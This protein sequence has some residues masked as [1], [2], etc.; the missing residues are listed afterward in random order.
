[1]VDVHDKQSRHKNMAAIRNK[2]TKPERDESGY[3]V[4]LATLKSLTAVYQ[5]VNSTRLI[6]LHAHVSYQYLR[7]QALMG[8]WR[9]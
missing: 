3:S 4:A 2:N 1:M 7:N 8:Y 6:F 5:F 9:S